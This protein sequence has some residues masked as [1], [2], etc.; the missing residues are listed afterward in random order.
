MFYSVIKVFFILPQLCS[1]HYI[2]YFVPSYFLTVFA[3]IAQADR[4][5]VYILYSSNNVG[6]HRTLLLTT[7]CHTHTAPCLFVWL[8][9]PHPPYLT[10][11]PL[12]PPPPNTPKSSNSTHTNQYQY[13]RFFMDA[14]FE[15][16]L[17]FKNN[18]FRVQNDK[19]IQ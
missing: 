3:L 15:I 16:F 1:R 19:V 12:H 7:T 4:L 5:A 2:L 13:Q 10:P 8:Y 11:T 14:I 9:A 17:K 18:L 6:T